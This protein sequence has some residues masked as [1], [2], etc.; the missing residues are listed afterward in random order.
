MNLKSAYTVYL[1]ASVS[2]KS[3]NNL[4]KALSD[5]PFENP[6]VFDI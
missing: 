4:W 6:S 1:P 5:M 2:K 3:F